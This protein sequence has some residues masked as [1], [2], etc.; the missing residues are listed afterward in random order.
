MAVLPAVSQLSRSQTQKIVL[1]IRNFSIYARTTGAWRRFLVLLVLLLVPPTV[2]DIDMHEASRGMISGWRSFGRLLDDAQEMWADVSE[3]LAG[4]AT[5]MR[6]PFSSGA[7]LVGSAQYD[8]PH[9]DPSFDVRR[10]SPPIGHFRSVVYM[11]TGC[12]LL[13]W[14]LLYRKYEN[15]KTPDRSRMLSIWEYLAVEH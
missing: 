1:N 13:W 5:V 9:D 10:S 6:G 3:R 8:D 15:S 2:L 12:C 4:K 14:L 7:E 11:P